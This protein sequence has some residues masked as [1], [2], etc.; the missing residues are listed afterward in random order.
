MRA[1][2]MAT[3]SGSDSGGGCEECRHTGYYGRTAV[4]EMVQVND[5][6]SRMIVERATTDALKRKAMR[7]GMRPLRHDGWSKIKA[8][9]TSIEEVLRVTMKEDSSGIGAEAG[10]RD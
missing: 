5:A 10:E 4:Y 8:G 7:N 3:I 1:L 9:V 2:I 6:F